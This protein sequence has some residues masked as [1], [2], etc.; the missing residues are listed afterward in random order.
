M[1]DYIQPTAP[2]LTAGHP[3]R[4]PLGIFCQ[5]ISACIIYSWHQ[6]RGWFGWF[7]GD[8]LSFLS[9][10]VLVNVNVLCTCYS[11][12]KCPVESFC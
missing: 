4:C 8:F 3:C 9:A 6:L 7:V 11:V 1:L 10:T 5:C 12:H 2:V